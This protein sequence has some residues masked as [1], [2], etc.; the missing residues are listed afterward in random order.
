MS[1]ERGM[2]RWPTNDHPINTT[3]ARKCRCNQNTRT[4]T[5][6]HT[7]VQNSTSPKSDTKRTGSAR[8]RSIER[9]RF[10]GAG[11]IQA[12]TSPLFASFLRRALS[13]GGPH[14]KWADRP[15]LA[16]EMLRWGLGTCCCSKF[17]HRPVGPSD[18]VETSCSFCR[19]VSH[20]A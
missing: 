20:R 2:L 11:T 6:A 17:G 5:C 19:S 4:C 14:P 18:S 1:G 7:R 3:S 8:K 9:S 13:A 10:A 12:P 16:I 15:N